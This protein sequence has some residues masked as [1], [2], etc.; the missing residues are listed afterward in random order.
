MAEPIYN[1]A[2]VEFP[3]E[4][5][6]GYTLDTCVQDDDV[7]GVNGIIL[8][9]TGT[10]AYDEFETAT[11][12]DGW[13]RNNTLTLDYGDSSG[14]HVKFGD[15]SIIAESAINDYASHNFWGGG[16]SV[17]YTEQWFYDDGAAITS[18][19]RGIFGIQG[20]AGTPWTLRW[21]LTLCTNTS[22]SNYEWYDAEDAAWKDTGIARSVG[23]HCVRYVYWTQI[24]E[25]DTI[26]NARLWLDGVLLKNVLD[27]VNDDKNYGRQKSFGIVTQETGKVVRVDRVRG[28]KW[29][30]LYN[31]SG[32]VYTPPALFP[33][34]IESWDSV[35]LEQ[36]IGGNFYKGSSTV[37]F[38]YSANGGV[39]WNGS[40]LL[41]TEANLATFAPNDD[42]DDGI[43]FRVTLTRYSIGVF[44]PRL[45]GL[46]LTIT[47]PALKVT[48]T[49]AEL[50]G[51][52]PLSTVVPGSI[53]TSLTRAELSG[54]TPVPIVVP[55]SIMVPVPGAGM[56]GA[57]GGVNILPG[58]ISTLLPLADV[59][60]LADSVVI[61]PG[62][63]SPTT[64]R[65]SATV[66]ALAT[67]AIP[68]EVTIPLDHAALTIGA[69][70]V[71]VVPGTATISLDRALL[72]TTTLGVTVAGSTITVAVDRATM[73]LTASIAS[74]IPG[75]A[76][77]TVPRAGLTVTA[78]DVTVLLGSL[79]VQVP[80]AE[81]STSAYAALVRLSTY[82]LDTRRGVTVASE[83]RYID[84]TEEN[85]AQ[86][87]SRE[88]RI[89]SLVAENRMVGV[90]EEDRRTRVPN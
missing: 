35:T 11:A 15:Q 47:P 88:E 34:G 71:S 82:S 80:R 78:D 29:G 55:G 28:D 76:T 16:G 67:S 12:G 5:L 17:S 13:Y 31:A 89:P 85:R 23:W 56:N 59:L 66:T 86:L 63:V 75:V 81:L 58:T 60:I 79:I 68:G 22:S 24:L 57:A 9:M 41:A 27:S 69:D 39:S 42:G 33:D 32:Y 45:K 43:K 40:W 51:T 61:V 50:T 3:I 30:P 10:A 53:A 38:Q 14:G 73:T 54:T 36:D 72:T 7:E 18:Q 90:M 26:H 2:S 65:A 70:G 77:V 25:P 46:T 74:A 20:V 1:G 49:R 87:V 37:H 8:T 48:V 19:R 6:T 64:D 44:T 62:A 21:A 52:L 4:D 83:T 84:V